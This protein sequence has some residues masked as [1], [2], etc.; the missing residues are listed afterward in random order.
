MV[1]LQ[2]LV[3]IEDPEEINDPQKLI[4]STQ[5]NN[6][7]KSS[8]GSFA[9]AKNLFMVIGIVV[10]AV[11]FILIL[12]VILSLIAKKRRKNGRK[13][14]LDQIEA[15]FSSSNEVKKKS[16][17]KWQTHKKHKLFLEKFNRND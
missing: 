14:W 13:H 9:G 10:G 16:A 4:A 17:E 8:S 6:S 11:A 1:H 7:P 5:K 15:E 2:I 3:G 12:I